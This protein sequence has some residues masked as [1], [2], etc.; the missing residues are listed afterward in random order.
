MGQ[1]IP[2]RAS[3]L[4]VV[5]V[6]A[7]VLAIAGLPAAFAKRAPEPAWPVQLA[8]LPR[9]VLAEH[10]TDRVGLEWTS[11]LTGRLQAAFGL[12]AGPFT[13]D[14]E[15]VARA[16]L[17]Q[18]AERFGL[19][20][21]LDDLRLD[22]A[23]QV[24]GGWHVRFTQTVNGV[25]VWRAG[26]VVSLNADGTRV[27]SV[28]SDYDPLLAG[29]AGFAAAALDERAALAAAAAAFGL[30]SDAQAMRAALTG[31][32]RVT[33][34]IVRDGDVP[35]GTA[36]LAYRVLLS[37]ADPT[38]EWVARIDAATGA[39]LGVE[40]GRVFIDGSG[41]PF[42]PDP[43]TTAQVLYGGNYS[44]NNDA[45]TAELNA[46]RF[47]RALY[48]IT[49]S[50][51]VYTLN[52]PFVHITNFEAP[53]DPA[54]T[55][56]TPDG[57]VF[58]RNQQGFEDVNAYFNIDT[59]QRYI[60]AL[61]FNNIQNGSITV[62]THGLN[63]DD[64]SYYQPG[65][66]R[67]A[68]GEGGVD[69]AEDADVLLHEYGHAIQSG[70]VPGWGGGQEGSMGEGFGDYWAGSS[71]GAISSYHENWVFNWDGHN[72]FWAGRVLD[73]TLHYPEGIQGEVHHD[74][75]IWSAPLWQSW[76]EVGRTVMD[77]LVLKSHFY[78]GTSATMPQ[79]ASAV[80]QADHDLYD[81]LHAA[82]LDYYFTA[83]GFFTTDQYQ[84]PAITHTPL[85]DTGDPGPYLVQCAIQ[86]GRPLVAGSVKIVYGVNGAFDHEA[87]MVPHGGIASY[88]GTIQS[89]GGDVVINYYI[90]AKNSDGWQGTS[91]RGAEYTH[92]EFSVTGSSGV[93][94]KGTPRALITLQPNPVVPG[95]G[96][97]LALPAT[98]AGSLAIY[99]LQGRKVRTLADGALSAGTTEYS[100]DGRN[101][102]G[103]PV[104]PGM[105]FVR[106]AAGDAVAV[107]K[108]ILSR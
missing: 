64:N 43:L 103:Q 39:L 72:P 56:P 53:N 11:R 67:I 65:S 10:P 101:D 14:A 106:L 17:A 46:Q 80:M 21:G 22:A 102:A 38:G 82:T 37:T 92:Y 30:P 81:G 75:P 96:I 57:F 70:S 9:V 33:L 95:G 45:D 104:G 27:T 108:V 84:E 40:D 90:K 54:V 5:L 94:D 105:Y 4:R 66:N 89:M 26:L 83:R 3:F 68:Y 16:Y 62:D 77:R 28:V 18:Q 76:H 47:T 12:D 61:G 50:G 60:Q 74:G 32:P 49:Y 31:E 8:S 34:Q 7:A 98:R 88:E 2:Y 78:L 73:S 59:S 41:M 42:D 13:G 24:P 97:R 51:G 69:D 107:R 19:R 79:G 85:P 15:T 1:E 71:S 36:N 99:D 29:R 91:P 6:L 25:D 87:V 44:D 100:W 55:S 20:A 58:T 48:G 35:G 93:D 52:G 23:Q 86:S 63:G